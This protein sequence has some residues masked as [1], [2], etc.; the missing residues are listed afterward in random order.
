MSI[1]IALLLDIRCCYVFYIHPFYVLVNDACKS[2][3]KNNSPNP[4]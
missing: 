4:T 1:R 2:N 3:L